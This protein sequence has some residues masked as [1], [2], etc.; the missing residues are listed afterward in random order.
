MS[1]FPTPGITVEFTRVALESTEVSKKYTSEIQ[2][3]A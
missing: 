1:Y 2:G 3:V